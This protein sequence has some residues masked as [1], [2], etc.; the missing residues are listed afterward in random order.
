MELS[1]KAYYSIVGGFK[2]EK[3]FFT[4]AH[5]SCS[6]SLICTLNIADRLREN[7][8]QHTGIR[9]HR[10]LHWKKPGLILSDLSGIYLYLIIAL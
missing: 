5:M 8:Y 3:E 6:R 4:K 10:R 1:K 2:N 7:W 9:Q